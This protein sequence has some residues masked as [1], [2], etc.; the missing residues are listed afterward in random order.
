MRIT[1]QVF[2][3]GFGIALAAC[4]APTPGKIVEAPH[5]AWVKSDENDARAAEVHAAA[6]REING[7]AMRVNLK[8]ARIVYSDAIAKAEDDLSVAVKK[9]SLV[10]AHVRKACETDARSIRDQSAENAKVRLSLADQ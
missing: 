3:C 4:G 1:A 2:V 8:R 6:S 7:A 5:D 9:C 10:P